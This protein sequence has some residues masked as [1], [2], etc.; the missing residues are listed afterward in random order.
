MFCFPTLTAMQVIA[1]TV[2]IVSGF[3]CFKPFEQARL[4]G[5]LCL[6]FYPGII[7]F[8]RSLPKTNVE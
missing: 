1:L 6:Y 8:N 4:K 3:K 7:S 5:A 2:K